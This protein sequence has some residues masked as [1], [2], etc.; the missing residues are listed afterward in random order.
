MPRLLVPNAGRR[1]L[2]VFSSHLELCSPP[3]SRDKHWRS[4]RP[5]TAGAHSLIHGL[6]SRRDAVGVR[7][8][9]SWVGPCAIG[10]FGALRRVWSLRLVRGFRGIL[11]FGEPSCRGSFSLYD[12]AVEIFY[13]LGRC[14]RGGATLRPT[15][16]WYRSILVGRMPLSWVFSGIPSC[17]FFSRPSLG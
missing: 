2:W 11:Y 10:G 9:S 6:C 15:L 8:L 4:T 14:R 5:V 12:A 7:G 13:R 3:V 16:H 1:V 17:S